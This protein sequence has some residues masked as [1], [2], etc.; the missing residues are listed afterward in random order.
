MLLKVCFV[1]VTVADGVPGELIAMLREARCAAV[2]QR[3]EASHVVD[4]ERRFKVLDLAHPEGVW[5]L[6]FGCL[7]MQVLQ[8]RVPEEA[9]GTG[10][11]VIVVFLYFSHIFFPSHVFG[12]L[13]FQQM[14][15]RVV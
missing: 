10:G 14:R 15:P 2:Q 4:L 12:F 9:V 5:S 7:L 6:I 13:H 11:E 1:V 8:E 3:K